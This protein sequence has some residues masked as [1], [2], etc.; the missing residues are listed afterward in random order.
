[1]MPLVIA[2]D[3][4]ISDAKHVTLN[5]T[6]SIRRQ[7]CEHIQK[8]TW[9]SKGLAMKAYGTISWLFCYHMLHY[10]GRCYSVCCTKGHSIVLCSVVEY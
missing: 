1:M 10:A 3:T 5:I 9:F 7:H 4:Y 2:L 8:L 6:A